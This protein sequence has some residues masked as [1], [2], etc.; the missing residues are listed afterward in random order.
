MCLYILYK[1]VFKH[2]T[3]ESAQTVIV[4]LKRIIQ[5]KCHKTPLRSRNR[6]KSPPD[7]LAGS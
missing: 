6:I 7:V 2:I 3:D 5:S 4:R 1:Y